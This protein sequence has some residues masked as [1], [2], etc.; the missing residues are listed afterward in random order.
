MVIHLACLHNRSETQDLF[1]LDENVGVSGASPAARTEWVP[2]CL[3]A[4]LPI[5][6]QSGPLP[7]KRWLVLAL[8]ETQ[9][10][11]C[12]LYD[13]GFCGVHPMGG[14]VDGVD[15]PTYRHRNVPL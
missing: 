6:F 2:R 8:Q 10:G 4:P 9:L 15:A 5:P 11:E 14:F 1:P 7:R 12:G 3:A 13:L